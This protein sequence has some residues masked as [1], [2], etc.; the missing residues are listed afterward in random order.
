LT[1]TGFPL[2]K[3]LGFSYLLIALMVFVRFI[4][5]IHV[6]RNLIRKYQV[7]RTADIYFVNT[8]EP[9]TPFSFFKWLFWN[10]KIDLQSKNGH[11]IFR[12]EL[13][14]IRQKHSWDL[15]FMEIVIAVFWMNPFFH[16]I[17]KELKTI[18]EFLADEFATHEND[19]WNYAE[20]LLRQVLGY[21]HNLPVNPFFHNQIKR[22]IAMITSSK[23]PKYQFFRKLMILP[24][25]IVVFTLF[26]F[27]VKHYTGF[28]FAKSEHTVAATNIAPDLKVLQSTSALQALDTT[29]PKV[30]PRVKANR[31][32]KVTEQQNIGNE[33][34]AAELKKVIEEKQFEMQKSQQEFQQLMEERRKETQKAQEEF[35][36][37]MEAHQRETQDRFKELMAQKQKQDENYQKE[38]K[39]MMALK[40]QDAERS[41]EE[42]QKM[43]DARQREA[44]QKGQ[45]TFK[46]LM[47][48][49][50]KQ[51]A[52]YEEEFKKMMMMRQKE[53]EKSQEE[54]R[55]LLEQ[56]QLE[57]Q[58]IREEFQKKT[59]EKNGK[60]VI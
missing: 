12:H 25:S 46:Q 3:I 47:E 34:E 27:K 58:K 9:G 6:I 7:E 41:R 36:R 55:K 59:L 33:N 44:E 13:F 52:K 26:A 21:S 22:R 5:A 53:A 10:N 23:T 51:G 39:E 60:Q 57:M 54:F 28:S 38:L 48:E 2:E 4:L 43:M 45:E 17:K 49:R 19:K 14:H 20:L 18:H 40:Q 56:R 35:R 1:P 16:L 32:P 29:K 42:F 37:L 31:Q 11:Q 24:V 50:Q 30:K 15:T 8:A